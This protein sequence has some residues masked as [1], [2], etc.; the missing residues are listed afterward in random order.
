MQMEEI[1]NAI[2]NEMLQTTDSGSFR[3]ISMV[4]SE[5]DLQN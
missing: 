2:G 4:E 3:I 1:Y 5:T